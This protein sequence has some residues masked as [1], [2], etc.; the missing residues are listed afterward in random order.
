MIVQDIKLAIGWRIRVYYAVDAYYPDEIA[1]DLIRIGCRGDQL[2][3]AVD[4]LWSG[5]V[6]TGL[7][8][9]NEKEKR[10]VMVIGMASCGG[11]FFNS[12]VH[13][14][15]HMV[16]YISKAEDIDPCGEETAYIA[17]E[18]AEKMYEESHELMCDCKRREI[19]SC[20]CSQTRP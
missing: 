8:Y 10:G 15:Q 20:F 5:E 9:A 4:N 2:R 7:T 1:D 3:T 19:T 14:M 6:N 17:G 11:E 12:L 16:S 18:L 13:E